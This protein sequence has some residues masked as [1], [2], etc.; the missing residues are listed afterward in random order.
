MTRWAK[1]L[2]ANIFVLVLIIGSA[3]VIGYYVYE[4]DK[5]IS[6]D[7]A[8][9]SANIITISA[10][11]P[12]RI[13]SWQVRPGDK[14]SLNTTLGSEQTVLSGGVGASGTK[15][16]IAKRKSSKLSTQRNV[17]A[18][19]GT[20]GRAGTP[21]TTTTPGT[22]GTSGTPGK[23]AIPATPGTTTTPATPAS[24]V[25]PGI[26]GTGTSTTPS[27]ATKAAPAKTSIT[28]P[29]AGTIIQNMVEE[30]QTVA[31]GQPLAM[32]ADLNKVFVVANIEE[33]R[34]SDVKR[35]QSVDITVDAFPGKVFD[36][37]VENIIHATSSTFS[38]IPTGTT[39]GS[40]TKVVQKIP[41]QISINSQGKDIFPGMSASVRIKK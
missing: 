30:G 36:G 18:T 7:D 5:Y 14:V 35:G 2:I 3:V 33:S 23:T 40:Y 25:T 28:A 15:P 9:I 26:A 8:R 22:S 37:T 38:L 16:A 19:P 13:S 31:M 17:A 39:S 24:P 4:K 20:P 21:G 41:V 6:T 11:T 34:I 29:I 1:I 32:L 12:G 10:S 27:G